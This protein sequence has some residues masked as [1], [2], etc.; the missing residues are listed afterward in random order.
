MSRAVVVLDRFMTFL[1]GL[2]LLVLG[3]AAILWWL[4]TFPSWPTRVD[5]S[6]VVQDTKAS[7]WPWAAAIAGI[8]LVLL[9]L[10]WLAAHLP[11]RGVAQVKLTGSGAQGRL[12]AQ[13]RSVADTA[14]EVLQQTPGVRSARGTIQRDR[15]QLVA[16]L[17]ATVEPGADLHAVAGAA[18]AVAADLQQVLGREDLRCRIQLRVAHRGRSQPRV[19]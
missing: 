3:A 8:V 7:W 18:D 11:S 17:R 1:A 6:V 5:A 13:V 14:A 10:R 9:G 16:R 4:G 2:I 19:T 12:S 15:G